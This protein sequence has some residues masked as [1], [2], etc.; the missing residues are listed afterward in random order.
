MLVMLEYSNMMGKIL[1]YVNSV[2]RGPSKFDQGEGSSK[3]DESLQQ[4]L[5]HELIKKL[6]K[7]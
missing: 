2:T 6:N 1:E 7:G 3:K 4:V 5:L